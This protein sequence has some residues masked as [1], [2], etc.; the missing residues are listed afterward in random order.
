MLLCVCFSYHGFVVEGEPLQLPEGIGGG[1]QL[2]EDHKGL[3]PHLHG[4]QGHDVDDLTKL[5]EEG[6]QGALHLCR[7]RREE[8]SDD[9]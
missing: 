9:Q 4:L 5:G 1:S 8:E 3:T 6:V 7:R 2:F